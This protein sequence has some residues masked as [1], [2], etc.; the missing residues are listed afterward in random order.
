MPNNRSK[1]HCFLFSTTRNGTSFPYALDDYCT[2]NCRGKEIKIWISKRI[3]SYRNEHNEEEEEEMKI[4]MDGMR[5]SDEKLR[6]R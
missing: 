1:M 5:P 2:R 6:Q 3:L 4:P